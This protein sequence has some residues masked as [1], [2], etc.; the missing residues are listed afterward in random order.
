MHLA[1]ITRSLLLLL[2]A[3]AC[4]VSAEEQDAVREARIRTGAVCAAYDDIRGR[5]TPIDTTDTESRELH[6]QAMEVCD[7]VEAEGG[8]RL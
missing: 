2:S 8:G 7:H 6:R 1:S 3:S 5:G 4:G